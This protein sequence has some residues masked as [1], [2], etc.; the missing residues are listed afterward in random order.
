MSA[1][2]PNVAGQWSAEKWSQWKELQA[3]IFQEVQALN[4]NDESLQA[5]DAILDAEE[6][7]KDKE[8]V[9]A[10]ASR[11]RAFTERCR[12]RQEGDQKRHRA[13]CRARMKKD[14]TKDSLE[15]P[16]TDEE[17]ATKKTKLSD[18]PSPATIEAALNIKEV[19]RDMEDF[20]RGE[21]RL[22]VCDSAGDKPTEHSLERKAQ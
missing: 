15:E 9:A 8:E 20:R 16:P 13:A 21:L 5:L 2:P 3:E 22:P 1:S 6:A 12:K 18:V 19:S 17:N 10:M 7:A 11:A 14:M 4:L